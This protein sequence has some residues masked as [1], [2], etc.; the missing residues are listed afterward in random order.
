MGL[1]HLIY[2]SQ[3]QQPFDTPAL[4]D[5]LHQARAFNRTH[6]LSGLLLYAPDGRFFQILEGEED[7]VRTLYYDHIV[8]DPRHHNCRLVGAGACAERSF[9]DWNMGFRVANAAELHAL[10]AAGTPHSLV[11]FAPQPRV[12]PELLSLLLDFVGDHELESLNYS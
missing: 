7:V 2:H 5:L 1:F 3:A 10:L 8:P 11:L 12:R 9:A 4:T 6:H